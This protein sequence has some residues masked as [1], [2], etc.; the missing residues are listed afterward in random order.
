VDYPDA[1]RLRPYEVPM[2]KL[3]IALVLAVFLSAGS[4]A[5]SKPK[6]KMPKAKKAQAVSVQGPDAPPKNLNAIQRIR[7]ANH[8][9]EKNRKAKEKSNVKY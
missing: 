8:Q 1:D 2:K 6:K 7:W 5:R 4:D 9:R 3:I